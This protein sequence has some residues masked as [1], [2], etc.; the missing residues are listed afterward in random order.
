MTL[1]SLSGLTER[2]E[3]I[4]D[5][6][7]ALEHEVAETLPAIDDI[8]ALTAWL[9]EAR[10]VEGLLRGRELQGPILGAQ[11]RAE[12]RIGKLLDHERAGRCNRYAITGEA[13]R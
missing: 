10:R 2:I 4:K 8:E 6:L 7:A 9:K 13:K 3:A 5:D 1:P 11:R 12:A